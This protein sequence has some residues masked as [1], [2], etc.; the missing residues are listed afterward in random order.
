MVSVCVCVSVVTAPALTVCI[1]M[2]VVVSFS[3]QE[4]IDVGTEMCSLFCS[5]ESVLLD[6]VNALPA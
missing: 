4:D 2:W 3:I 6:W 5:C 1:C